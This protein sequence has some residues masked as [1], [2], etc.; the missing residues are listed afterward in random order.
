M[1]LPAYLQLFFTYMRTHHAHGEATGSHT[2]LCAPMCMHICHFE[3]SHMTRT[4]QD[5]HAQHHHCQASFPSPCTYACM[6]IR[7]DDLA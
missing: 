7:C 1:T 3:A 2:R 6:H 4:M 5:M